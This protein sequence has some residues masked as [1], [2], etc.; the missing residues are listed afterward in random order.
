MEQPAIGH[1]VLARNSG[2]HCETFERYE[3][4]LEGIR[5]LKLGP[6]SYD[7]LPWYWRKNWDG[8]ECSAFFQDNGKL[9]GFFTDPQ[10][11]AQ[12]DWLVPPELEGLELPE[13]CL[14][15]D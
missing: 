3:D 10:G 13:D 6:D 1:F 11:D 7:S 4:L 12:A 9:D 15:E 14:P 5:K 2:W 8:T